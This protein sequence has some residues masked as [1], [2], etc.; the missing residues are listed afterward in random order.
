MV[1]CRRPFSAKDT[2][3]SM[4]E[5]AYKAP[6]PLV[7]VSGA[8][9]DLIGRTLS[10]LPGARPQSAAKLIA[11]LRETKKALGPTVNNKAP[12]PENQADEEDEITR[13]GRIDRKTTR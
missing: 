6:R 13:V 8:L 12:A 3:Q 10:K 1:A 5:H 7:G 11:D 2:L 9:R 4:T